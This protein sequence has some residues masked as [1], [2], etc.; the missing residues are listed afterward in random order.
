MRHWH[1]TTQ[2]PGADHSREVD[3]VLGASERRFVA[4]L[5]LLE[6]V[7]RRAMRKLSAR[8]GSCQL[9]DIQHHDLVVVNSAH[10]LACADLI[11]EPG[12]HG[13]IPHGTVQG[14][15]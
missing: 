5:A 3:R 14:S 15:V 9:P 8:P 1:V 10:R 11:V 13:T 4:Q 7:H 12:E 6:V 2:H